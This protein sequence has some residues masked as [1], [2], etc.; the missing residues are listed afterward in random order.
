MR[1]LAILTAAVLTAVQAQALQVSTPT[2]YSGLTWSTAIS[3]PGYTTCTQLVLD[4][5][6]D[7]QNSNK[8][9]VFGSLNCGPS[10]Y[11]MT[12]SGY[13]AVDGSINMVLTVGV[14]VVIACPRLQNF[15]GTCFV[16]D[17][18]GFQRG[19]A[20]LTFR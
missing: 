20:A 8:I 4:A 3:A 14:G 11:V 1:N 2:L 18:A 6:G 19:T 5:M 16:F 12:G 9:S 15:G 7:L 13:F 10:G 17:S